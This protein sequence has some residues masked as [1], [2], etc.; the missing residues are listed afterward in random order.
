MIEVRHVRFKLS[1]LVERV[2]DHLNEHTTQKDT[3]EFYW[4]WATG[5]GWVLAAVHVRSLGGAVVGGW[6][7]AQQGVG[8]D[9][10]WDVIWSGEDAKSEPDFMEAVAGRPKVMTQ[11][12]DELERRGFT[13]LPVE[14]T[15]DYGWFNGMNKLVIR[16]SGME[17]LTASDLIL[18]GGAGQAVDKLI[19]NAK[20]DLEPGGSW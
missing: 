5:R 15:P 20:L 14:G 12:G 7:G 11:L 6:D 8:D 2:S 16:E 1:E 9:E 17:D 10:L 4:T 3:L 19:E 18:A 13:R